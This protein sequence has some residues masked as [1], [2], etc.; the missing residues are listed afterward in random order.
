ME[1]LK[2]FLC[3]VHYSFTINV[4]P[5]KYLNKKQWSAYTQ[6]EQKAAFEYYINLNS[7]KLRNVDY[8]YEKCPNS[9]CIHV[10]GSF[11]SDEFVHAELFQRT[12]HSIFGLPR[13]DPKICCYIEPTYFNKKPWIKYKLKEQ[14]QRED[15]E[16][17][18]RYL[19]SI[20]NEEIHTLPKEYWDEPLFQL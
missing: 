4:S 11:Y 5:K 16:D 12:M 3:D 8:Y 9:E 10:H 1:E 20:K 18:M 14:D 15:E 17:Y 19:D 2:S 6:A 7:E 13:C